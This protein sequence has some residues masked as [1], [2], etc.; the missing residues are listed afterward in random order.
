MTPDLLTLT[1]WV[2]PAFPLGGFAYSHGLETAVARG[3]VTDADSLQ[4][5]LTGVLRAGAGQTDAILLVQ[6][7]RGADVAGIATA[8]AAS[9]ERLQETL[10]QGAA[11]ARTVN[12][13]TGQSLPDAPLPVVVGIASRPL[14]LPDQT[15]IALCLQAFTSN[16]VTIGVRHIPL[17]QTAGQAVLNALHPL[18]TDIA[19]RAA[20]SDLDAIGNACF[21]SDMAAMMHETQQVRIFKT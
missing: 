9:P 4:N 7:R 10:A 15:V 8:L 17:G 11:F 18:I 3:D 16:L 19:E 1:Q 13:M 5:W 12:T 2:S 20:Q 14:D 6:A 21:A